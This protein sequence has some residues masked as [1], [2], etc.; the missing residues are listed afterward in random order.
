MDP[1]TNTAP[2]G[3]MDVNMDAG[4]VTPTPEAEEGQTPETES[5]QTA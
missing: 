5:E 1:E 2:Q 4:E 3:E